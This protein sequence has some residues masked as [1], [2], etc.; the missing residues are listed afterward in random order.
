MWRLCGGGFGLY[1]KTLFPRLVAFIMEWYFR[2]G[3]AKY[4]Y[5]DFDLNN[6]LSIQTRNWPILQELVEADVIVS[7]TAWQR[8]QFPRPWRDQINV[9][10]DGVNTNL[11]FRRRLDPGHC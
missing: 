7:P 4:L 1:L 6:P 10:F 5:S 3:T 9:I 8:Q 11:F 2:P